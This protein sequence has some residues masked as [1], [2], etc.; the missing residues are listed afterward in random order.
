MTSTRYAVKWTE[1]ALNMVEA[2][3]D[4]RLRA[5]IADRAGELAKDPEQ[6][7]TALVHELSGFRSVRAA[8]Q[9]FRIIDTVNRRQVIVHIV[10]AGRRK[11][12]HKSDI[13][14]LARKLVRQGL[15]L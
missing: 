4:A 6:Q 7:G 12:G 2:I 8:G 10:A 14:E 5:L 1:T 3:P 9:R 15:A 11:A 13:Y